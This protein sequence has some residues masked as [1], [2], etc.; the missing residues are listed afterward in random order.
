MSQ[1][2]NKTA[3][4]NVV[5]KQTQKKTSK[6]KYNNAT[7]AEKSFQTQE[8]IIEALVAL[9][10]ERK[11]GE[12]QV[13]EIADRTGIT[14]RT[15]FRFFKDKKTLHRAMDAYILK[16][17]H[18]GNEQLKALGF[19]AFAKSAFEAFDR[20]EALTTAY[21]LSPFGQEARTIFRKRL[22]KAMIAQICEENKLQMTKE[23]SQRLA[24]VT[25]LVNA[26]IWYDI[27]NDYG[28]SGKEMSASVEWALETLL[29]NC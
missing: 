17:F 7:R 8:S 11:G 26:K 24:I 27:R 4:K 10:V 14:Q 16:Y 5:T 19:V 21:V 20:N 6:R 3:K 9:L 15:I 18:S 12:V 13:G 23:R 22:N 29:S 25:S 28:F 1:Q 2:K